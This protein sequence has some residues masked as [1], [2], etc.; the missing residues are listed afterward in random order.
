M[1]VSLLRRLALAA[2]F[3]A[4]LC[5]ISAAAYH[6]SQ[7]PA[8]AQDEPPAPLPVEL[9]IPAL[10]IDAP[11]WQ[12]GEDD[13]GGMESP[14]S[15]TAVGW[16]APGF[17]PGQPGNAVIAGHVDWVDHAAVFYFLKN[18]TPGDLVNVVMDDGSVLTFAVDEVDQY[19]DGDTPMDRIFGNADQPHLNLITC[20]G[21]FDRSTHNYDHRLVVYTTLV[22]N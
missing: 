10:R 21:V 16:F 14:W 8:L 18:L 1:P 4:L 3:A 9:Q 7:R 13:S 20:G 11:I 17:V 12:V 19:D 15:D 6:R 22:G 5:S 2:A